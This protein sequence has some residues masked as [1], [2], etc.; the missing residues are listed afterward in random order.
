MND[1]YDPLPEALLTSE[2]TND[3]VK[4]IAAFAL[5]ISAIA[6]I[7]EQHESNNERRN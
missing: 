6:A 2:N 1:I 4:A 7:V 5:L 3:W